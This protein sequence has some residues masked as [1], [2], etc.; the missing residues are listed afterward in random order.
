MRIFRPTLAA[1]AVGILTLAGAA[2]LSAQKTTKPSNVD[3]KL[4]RDAGSMN[5][6]ASPDS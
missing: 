5:N 1:L 2:W 6:D 4:L 3:A